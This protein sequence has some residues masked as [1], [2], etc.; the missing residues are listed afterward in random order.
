MFRRIGIA[1][2]AAAALRAQVTFDREFVQS[3]RGHAADSQSTGGSRSDLVGRWLRSWVAKGCLDRNAGRYRTTIVYRHGKLTINGKPL[4]PLVRGRKS[5]PA[6]ASA[7][8]GQAA[9]APASG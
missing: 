2:V 7:G 9:P 1:V 6:P 3:M 5:A 4:G 8:G